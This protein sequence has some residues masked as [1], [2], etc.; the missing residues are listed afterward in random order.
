MYG[1]DYVSYTNGSAQCAGSVA[2]LAPVG[3]VVKL[4]VL[5]DRTSMELFGNDGAVSLSSC[6][7]PGETERTTTVQFHATNGTVL[8]HSLVVH[9]LASI[10]TK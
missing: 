7:L 2:P 3:N 6:F 9:R 1:Y 5:V 10:W 8:I 4:R